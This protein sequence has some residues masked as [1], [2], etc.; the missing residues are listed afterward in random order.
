MPRLIFLAKVIKTTKKLGIAVVRGPAFLLV[1]DISEGVFHRH[2]SSSKESVNTG[3]RII[4]VD[5]Q[6][7]DGETLHKFMEDA[8]E[9]FELELLQYD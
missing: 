8:E 1:T 2:N 5:G 7:G 9:S 4:T 6:I 3:S